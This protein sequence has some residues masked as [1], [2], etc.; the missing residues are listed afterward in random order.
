V[1]GALRGQVLAQA[2]GELEEREDEHQ[3]EE[4]FQERHPPRILGPA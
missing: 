4:Q 3:V 2:V 1:Y